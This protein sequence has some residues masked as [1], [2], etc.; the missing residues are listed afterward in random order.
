MPEG[1][2]SRIRIRDACDEDM[3]RIHAI[4]VH[5]VRTGLGSFEE[6][7]PDLAEMIRRRNEIVARGLPYLVAETDDP[8]VPGGIAGYAYAGPYRPRSAY[9]YSVEDSIYVA[10]EGQRRGAGRRLL[11]EL[12]RRCTALGYRQMVAVIGDSANHGSIGVHA[13]AGFKQVALLPAIGLKFG[14]WVDSVMMQR[15]LG[16]GQTTLPDEAK[17]R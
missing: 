17:G 6:T 8:A 9:R 1:T 7:P 3:P 12:V 13:A 10:P 16:E 14:R 4:Y 11:D 5:H 15:P 2:P